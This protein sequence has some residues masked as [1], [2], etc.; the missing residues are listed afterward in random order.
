MNRTT[1]TAGRA[2]VA[3]TST[4]AAVLL[5]ASPAVASQPVVAYGAAWVG[6]WGATTAT[7][8]AYGEL[9]STSTYVAGVWTLTVVGVRA[10]GLPPVAASFPR[11]GRTFGDCL[12]VTTGAVL[13]GFTGTLTYTG[14][15][16]GD[17][18][19]VA[20]VVGARTAATAPFD[21]QYAV[22]D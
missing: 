16:T 8:C 12:T 10:D 9:D 2:F 3:L 5:G 21:V 11:T 14:A 13:A 22:S 7:V 1:C 15:G 20:G 19:T 17:V 6:G 18:T 4:A